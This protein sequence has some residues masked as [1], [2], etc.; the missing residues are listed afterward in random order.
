M[1]RCASCGRHNEAEYRFCLGCGRALDPSTGHRMDP[2]SRPNPPPQ[3]AA[4]APVAGT[5]EG[6]RHCAVCRHDYDSDYSFCPRC[7]SAAGARPVAQEGSVRQR[8]ATP[9]AATPQREPVLVVIHSD[10]QERGRIPIPEQG[11]RVGRTIRGPLL[12]GDP[13]LSP[14]HAS[15]KVES[16]HVVVRDEGSLNGTFLRVRD[17]WDL[18][19]HDVLRIGQKLLR[20]ERL[21]AGDPVSGPDGTLRLGSPCGEAWGRLGVVLGPG[22][23]GDAYLLATPTV[24]IGRERGDILFPEDGFVSARHGELSCSGERVQLRDLGSSNGT[25]IRLR[26]ETALRD[27]DF[28]LLGQQLF[29]LRFA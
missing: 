14:L 1:P 11:A 26:A 23:V 28:L 9:P 29:L 22:R 16:G 21:G 4:G 8:L 24:R 15:F 27:G 10:G 18:H 19:H 3:P 25:F 20:F 12:G 7:G 17:T 2:P 13:F 6:Q 5:S